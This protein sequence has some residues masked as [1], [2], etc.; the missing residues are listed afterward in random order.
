MLDQKTFELLNKEVDGTTSPSE[1]AQVRKLLAK[2]AEARRTVE[3][4]QTLT[5][6]LKSISQIDP[7][8]YL[9]TKIMN[10]VIPSTTAPRSIQPSLITRIKTL[11][12]NTRLRTSYAF[13]GGALAG[14]L[15]F[16]VFMG[17][18]S[19]TSTLVGTM[20]SDTRPISSIVTA[21]IDLAQVQGT[22]V[23]EL[24]G[25]FVHTSLSLK[26][27]REIEVILEFSDQQL[28]FESVRAPEQP[29]ASFMIHPGELRLKNFGNNVFTL[30]FKTTSTDPVSLT[31]TIMAG[32]TTLS[33]NVLT[34]ERKSN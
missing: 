17:T 1:R 14:I 31:T 13:V 19:D 32:E 21:D 24:A 2:N 25:E 34:L 27:E 22:V 10:A 4:L 7:P 6:S 33:R 29:R 26:S 12:Q 28:H 23:A 5:A 3:E 18:P 9:K 15:L 20:G 16:M 30:V 11:T 8:S